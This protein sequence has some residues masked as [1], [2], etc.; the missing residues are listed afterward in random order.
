MD[1]KLAVGTYSNSIGGMAIQAYD[2]E[3]PFGTFTVNLVE[4]PIQPYDALP[5]NCAYLDTNNMPDLPEILQKEGLAEPV[6]FQGEPV[7]RDSGY[8][9]YPLY[10]FD[11]DKLKEYDPTGYE[12]YSQTWEKAIAEQKAKVYKQVGADVIREAMCK[13]EAISEP[14]EEKQLGE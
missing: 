13:G 14:S 8:C 3:G 5:K 9:T 7:S 12:R 6:L 1:L 11:V 2:D 4:R 10:E